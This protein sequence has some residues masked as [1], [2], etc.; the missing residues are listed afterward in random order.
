[1]NRWLEVTVL[2]GG[3]TGLDSADVFYFGNVVGE[4]DGDWQVGDSDY[5]TLVSEFGMSGGFGTLA[6]D[7][8]A[9][10]RVDLVDFA[11]MRGA[12]GNNV[13]VPTPPPAPAPA[14]ATAI[15]PDAD[16]LAGFTGA[17]EDSTAPVNAVVGA[18]PMFAIPAVSIG[19]LTRRAPDR[20]N[21]RTGVTVEDLR[22]LRDHTPA[23]R[24]D[25]LLVDVLAESTLA[26]DL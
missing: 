14:V 10:G 3:A 23:N 24:S 9:S 7:F 12:F 5:D 15:E 17:D 11:I 4:T 21:L 1:M 13:G 19:S 18:D 8:N 20:P 2:A 22:A 6:S 16:L 25:E 26:L